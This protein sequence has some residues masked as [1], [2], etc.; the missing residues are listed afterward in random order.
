M[1]VYFVGNITLGSGISDCS[2]NYSRD[3]PVTRLT[4]NTMINVTLIFQNENMTESNITFDKNVTLSNVTLDKNVTLSNGTIDENGNLANM[5]NSTG[6][7]TSTL[8]IGNLTLA[9]QDGDQ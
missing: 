2:G 8:P 6:N 1:C 4:C 3:R 7:A 9:L 5:T